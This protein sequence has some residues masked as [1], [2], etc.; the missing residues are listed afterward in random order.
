[1]SLRS[2]LLLLTRF[3]LL[4]ELANA[5]D[6]FEPR[7]EY[8]ERLL[9]HVGVRIA[10]DGAALRVA[11]D[12]V[13]A[14]DALEHPRRDGGGV[15]A[16]LLEIAVLRAEADLRARERVLHLFRL[17]GGEIAEIVPD[18]SFQ[19]SDLGAAAGRR[20]RRSLVRTVLCL[21]NN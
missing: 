14:A 11:A 19:V 6:G 16:A 3:A 7:V 2:L 17:P 12:D 10:E 8:L 13:V 5:E 9:V 4:L 21:T 15:R 20:T 1:M 18:R